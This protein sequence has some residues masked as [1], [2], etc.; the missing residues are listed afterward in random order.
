VVKRFY[1]REFWIYFVI[2]GMATLID[3]SIFAITFRWFGLHYSAALVSSMGLAGSFHYVANKRLTF[4]CE[5]RQYG[6]QVPIYIVVALFGLGM[7][8]GIMSILINFIGIYP[9]IA[10]ILTTMLMLLPNYLMHK[11][12]TFSQK[13]FQ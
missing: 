6:R 9:I 11:Y 13:L 7:S 1:N 8:M 10:R 5:S 4:Q 12:I 2:G 3:W